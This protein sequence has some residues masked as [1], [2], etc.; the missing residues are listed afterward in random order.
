M[1]QVFNECKIISAA[2]Q[3]PNLKK[4]LTRAKFELIKDPLP[5]KRVGLYPCGKCKYCKGGYLVR[6][7]DFTVA[8]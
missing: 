2:R 7:S 5:P 4:L 1:K 3:P 8:V 6:A